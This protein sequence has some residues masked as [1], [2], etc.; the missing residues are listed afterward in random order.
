MRVAAIKPL[1]NGGRLYF[2]S[3]FSAHE[4]NLLSISIVS[5]IITPITNETIMSKS[6]FVVI[7]PSLITKKSFKNHP[8]ESAVSPKPNETITPFCIFFR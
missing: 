7:T 5:P 6:P 2:F 4:F 1:A 8:R 3:I